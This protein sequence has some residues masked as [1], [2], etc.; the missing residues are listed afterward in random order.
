VAGSFIRVRMDIRRLHESLT[1]I[2]GIEFA[3]PRELSMLLG[4]DARAAG[5]ILA[6]MA[7]HGLAVRWSRSFYRLLPPPPGKLE[8]AGDRVP[9]G[10]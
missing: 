1:R 4:I 5:R 2:L 9:E 7:E 8:V 6:L 3:G 10:R